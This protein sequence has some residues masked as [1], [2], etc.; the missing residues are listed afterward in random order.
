M[1]FIFFM[2]TVVGIV[3]RCDNGCSVV[4]PLN[5]S[6]FATTMVEGSNPLG[7]TYVKPGFS[8]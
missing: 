7:G 4:E 2:S 8:C 3:N 5:P 6:C 1:S